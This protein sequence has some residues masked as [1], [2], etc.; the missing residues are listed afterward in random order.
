MR[1]R[2]QQPEESDVVVQQPGK[3]K[4]DVPGLG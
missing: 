3:E 1:E 2:R 4:S